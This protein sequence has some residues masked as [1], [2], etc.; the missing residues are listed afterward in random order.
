MQAVFSRSAFLV[1]ILFIFAIGFTTIIF[2][3]SRPQRPEPSTKGEGKRN[4]RPI[5][6]TEE[7]LKKE[8]EEQKRL[9]EEKKAVEEPGVL[10]VNTDIVNVDAV[11]FNKKSGQIVGGLKRENFAIF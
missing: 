9:E 10:K 7:E 3:Q 1:S 4:Q 6:K 2:G 8:A 5:P 11:V